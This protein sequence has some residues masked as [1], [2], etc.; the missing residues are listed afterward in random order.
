MHPL[1]FKLRHHTIGVTSTCSEWL[2]QG[3]AKLHTTMATSTPQHGLGTSLHHAGDTSQYMQP[4]QHPT[5]PH[6]RGWGGAR[7]SWGQAGHLGS[8]SERVLEHRDKQG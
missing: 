3:P 5:A 4:T 8:N 2:H 1:P 6:P 7:Y